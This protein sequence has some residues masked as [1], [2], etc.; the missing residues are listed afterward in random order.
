MKRI[1]NYLDKEEREVMLISMS[2]SRD[3]QNPK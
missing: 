1:T 3:N 2:V